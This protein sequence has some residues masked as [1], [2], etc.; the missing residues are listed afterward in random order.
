MSYTLSEH[1]S[2]QLLRGA[3]IAIPEDRL[4][5]GADAAVRAAEELGFPV[6]LKLCGRKIAH[7]TERGLVRLG[8]GDAASVR[9]AATA[10][11][12]A[13]RADD[14]DA[15]VLVCRMVSGRREVIAGL[16]RDPQ[17]GPCVMLGLGGIFAE[18]VGDAAFAVAPLARGD[19][20]DL[21]DA[22]QYKKVLGPFRGEPAVDRAA[23][24]ALLESLGRIGAERADVRAIDI[25]PLIVAG[26]QPVVIDALVELEGSA[27]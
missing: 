17:F 8:L 2:K 12:A 15:R 27:T 25:N 14:G 16:V 4:V 24:A 13:R 18:A 7:K 10:L 19:A 21:I 1:E 5:E 11:L 20:E 6:A 9:A 3:G 26:D 23:L 22:L